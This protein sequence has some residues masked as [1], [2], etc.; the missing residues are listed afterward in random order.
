MILAAHILRSLIGRVHISPPDGIAGLLIAA[1]LIGVDSESHH[2]LIDGP[3]GLGVIQ[4][5][6]A[7]VTQVCREVDVAIAGGDDRAV[8]K[9]ALGVDIDAPDGENLLGLILVVEVAQVLILKVG[10]VD[11][12]QTLSVVLLGKIELESHGSI[13]LD[14]LYIN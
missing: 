12:E 2:T 7:D 13:L 10:S 6:A 14:F 11:V 4:N 1:L 8:V 5:L 3:D 9:L